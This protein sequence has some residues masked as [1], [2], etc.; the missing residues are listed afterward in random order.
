M[1][2]LKVVT[3]FAAAHHSRRGLD[4]DRVEHVD[5]G[6]LLGPGK[7]KLAS[8]KGT[9]LVLDE[10]WAVYVGHG[11]AAWMTNGEPVYGAMAGRYRAAYRLVPGFGLLDFQ[12]PGGRFLARVLRGVT[13]GPSPAWMAG[14]AR[15]VTPF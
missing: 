12:I 7:V 13:P 14:Q 9:V 11:M 10:G 1:Y 2:E 6:L 5:F 8:R 15:M 3:R 4:G